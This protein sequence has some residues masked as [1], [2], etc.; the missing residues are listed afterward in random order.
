AWGDLKREIIDGGRGD[1]LR[2]LFVDLT[3]FLKSDEGERFAANLA[4]VLAAAARAGSE[5]VE[6]LAKD[7][8]LVDAGEVITVVANTVAFLIENFKALLA[9]MI[10]IQGARFVTTITQLATEIMKAR[11]AAL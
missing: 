10:A 6:V 9:I 11:A 4:K 7:G 2:D 8:G 5:L 3:N 1:A